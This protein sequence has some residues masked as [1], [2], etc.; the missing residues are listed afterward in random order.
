MKRKLGAHGIYLLPENSCPYCGQ[1]VTRRARGGKCPWCHREIYPIKR[2]PKGHK[3]TV[4][5]PTDPDIKG[6]V[7]RALGH[8]R[9]RFGED[10]T[11]L[12]LPRQFGAAKI[13]FMWCRG[14]QG[15]AER[16]VDAWYDKEVRMLLH[17]FENHPRSLT[18]MINT[19]R[20]LTAVVL[21]YALKEAKR[22]E[23][24]EQATIFD[25]ETSTSYDDW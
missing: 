17:I 7:V 14:D 1:K 25:L 13:I 8:I 11:F 10:F 2:G 16:F 20:D 12:D 24:I 23:A 15:A 21:S 9:E 22:A 5:V 18:E 19:K 3:E 4:Y 6:L